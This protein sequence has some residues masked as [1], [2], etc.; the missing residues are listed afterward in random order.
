[1]L[2]RSETQQQLHE[3]IARDVAETRAMAA[4]VGSALVQQIASSRTLIA[5]TRQLIARTDVIMRGQRLS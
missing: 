1:M 5:E 4:A 2:A 3:R